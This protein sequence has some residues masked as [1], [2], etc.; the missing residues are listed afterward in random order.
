MPLY[1]YCCSKHGVFEAFKPFS[2]SQ[3]PGECPEC[4]QA[5]P[6]VLSLPRTRVMERGTRIAMERNEKSKHEPTRRSRKEVEAPPVN[7]PVV[8]AQQSA[9]ARSWMIG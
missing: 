2:Q 9:N 4:G 7:Q 1:E 8:K 3:V 6:R 5:S